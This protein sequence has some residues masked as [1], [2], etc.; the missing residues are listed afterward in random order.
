MNPNAGDLEPVTADPPRAISR[1]RLTQSWLDV[2]FV[3][4]A[5]EPAAVAGLLPAGTFPDTMDGVTYVGLVPFRMHR[6]G[7]W[8]LPAVPYLGSFPE[9]NVRVYSVDERGRRGVVFL[10]LD[11]ARLL[12]V[13]AG[14]MGFGLPYAWSAMTVQREASTIGYTCRRR[15]PAA[16]DARGSTRIHVGQPIDE[17]SALE[18]FLTARWG[19]HTGRLGRTRYL[20]NSH[21]RWRLY[22]ATLLECTGGLLTAAGVHPRLPEPVSV[23]YSPGVPVRFGRPR[24][25]E[26][27]LRQRRP[28]WKAFRRQVVGTQAPA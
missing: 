10:S 28:I 27:R 8:R 1:P 6:V 2:T 12:P 5:V 22:R 7:W 13:L 19:L 21:P 23:L 16:P 11:A 26:L 24:S 20:P 14:R 17:P 18:H 4:W 9:T 3:H 15:W 25:V